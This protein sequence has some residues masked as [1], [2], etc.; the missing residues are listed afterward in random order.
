MIVRLPSLTALRAFEATARLQSVAA[1]ADELCVTPGAVSL[2]IKELETALGMALFLRRPRRLVLTHPGETYYRSIRMAFSLMREA[3]AEMMA[4]P[5]QGRLTVAC[6]PGFAVQWLVPRL[7]RFEAANPGVDVR[8]SASNRLCD[9]TQDG[10]DLAIRHGIGP[11][12]GL[13]G[14]RLIDD[15]LVPVCSPAL[16]DGTGCPPALDALPL[17]HDEHRH[18]WTL[19]A[20]AAGIPTGDTA[21]GTVFTDGN[22]AV[23]AA[24]AGL[25]IALARRSLVERE[26]EAGTLV[27]PFPHGVASAFAYYLV[28]PPEAMDR[29]AVVAFRSWLLAESGAVRPP[30]ATPPRSPPSSR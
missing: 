5:G 16:L 15:D 29:P 17:L 21:R 14:E 23:E 22:G 4:R 20:D 28:F 12:E 6:T 13:V 24:K 19:W 7:G 11:Y 30:P 10:I 26:L 2:Q 18:D 1:A 8:I 27:A 3:T 9:F 25:G